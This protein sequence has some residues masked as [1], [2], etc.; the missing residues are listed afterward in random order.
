M[1]WRY[2]GG[3]SESFDESI[4]AGGWPV[5]ERYVK[6]ILQEHVRV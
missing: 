2:R 1:G 6:R 5:C 4:A 3:W